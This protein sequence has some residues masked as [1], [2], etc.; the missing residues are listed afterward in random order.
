MA[1]GS[2]M[3][4]EEEEIDE[5]RSSKGQNTRRRTMTNTS[6]EESRMDDEV[7][8]GDELRSSAVPNTRRRIATKTSLEENST[9]ER[10]VAVT[11]QESLDGIREKA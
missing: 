6:M 2:R 7:E 11:T 1:S 10:T 5:S 4:V 9:N 3:E 8:E